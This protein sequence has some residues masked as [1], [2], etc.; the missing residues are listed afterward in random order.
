MSSAAFNK[1]VSDRDSNSW[2][3]FVPVYGFRV[4]NPFFVGLCVLIAIAFILTGYRELAGLGPVS[5]MNDA[6]GWGIWKT[7]NVMV[8][9]ALGSG[10]F[11]VGIAAWVFRRHRLHSLM[12]VALLTSFLAYA[13]GLL[14]L[15]IDAGRP[16]NFY[17][18]VFPWKWN[19]H[20]PLAEVAICMSIYAMIPLAL[21]NIPPILERLWYFDSR[22]RPRVEKLEKTLYSAF[23]WI[24]AAAYLLPGMHQSSLGALMLLAGERV[25][26][27]W[28]TPFLPLL[29]LG[30]ACFMSFGCVAGTTMLCCLIWKRP[31]DM[32]VLDDAATI[33]WWLIA[34]WLALRL[35]DITVRGAILTAFHFDR[36]ALVFW[37]EVF[38][39][40]YG[41]WLLYRSVKEHEPRFMFLG[42]ILSSLGG[43]IYRF[44][45]TTL[46][47][48]PNPEALYFPKTIEI[49]VSL[50]F[51][52]L[53]IA[54][55]L[56]A[57][58]RLAILPAPT[59]TWH[60]MA[61]YFR[62]R[63]PY[64]RWTGYFQ[65]GH[66]GENESSEPKNN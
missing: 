30:A 13:C 5:G 60:D 51:I 23:P 4:L 7:F 58:K 27:L 64:I 45:P 65:F 3:R 52:S 59:H 66:L 57:V 26:P 34:G 50:G 48:R 42:Y 24:I 32:E 17:W 15:G 10:A 63:R 21:E 41:G 44:S 61:S 33:T 39:T 43:M 1:P 2:E 55:F 6:F 38:L 47:F 22:L 36:F 16:W 14:L 18:I 8:L 31:M 54:G 40:A 19:M 46:A 9:T 37:M 56:F 20:S 53:G 28:Q 11:A 12:R 49:L 35:V 62:F 29:Y 25:H